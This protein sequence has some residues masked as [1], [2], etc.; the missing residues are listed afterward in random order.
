MSTRTADTSAGEHNPATRLL[1]PRPS[2]E[3]ERKQAKGL[4]RRLRAADPHAIARA[5]DQHVAPHSSLGADFTLA[6]AQFVIAREYGFASWPRLV[7][8]FGDV[9]RQRLAR[10]S[11]NWHTRESYEHNVDALIAQHGNRRVHAG[12]SFAASVPRFYGKTVDEVFAFSVTE[13]D[14]R[15]TVARLSGRPS[16]EMLMEAVDTQRARHADP[17]NRESAAFALARTAILAGDLAAF[18]GVIAEHPELLRPSEEDLRERHTVV[19]LALAVEQRNVPGVRAITDWLASQGVD[20]VLALSETLCGAR[21]GTTETVRFLLER[22]ANPNWIAPNGIS[23]LEH[24]LLLYWNG[25]AVDLI[26]QRATPKR[27]LWIDAGL[28]DVD[29]LSRFLDRHG[30]PTAAAY[31]DRPDFVAAGWLPMLPTPMPDSTEV[32]AEAF[33]VAMLNDRVAVLDYMIDRGFPVDYLELD[34]PFVSFAAGNQR[35]RVFE[36]LVRRGA[37]LDLRGRQPDM[38]AREMARERFENAPTDPTARRILELCGL[39]PEH[40]IAEME[41]RPA[42][43]PEIMPTLQEAFDLAGDD[44]LRLGQTEVTPENVLIGM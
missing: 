33:M 44:A 1:P 28:G 17:F 9:E 11:Y 41:A 25:D 36:C 30:K 18:S 10:R 8:Y 6:D 21:F 24:A 32:L 5:H 13:D 15:L 37:D 14:A 39:E 40:V 7:Q 31:R 2:L 19:A 22:G 34:M 29:G 26:A 38:T 23:A 16:W 3:F 35:L 27:A 43:E 12:R 20:V 42:T 4:L